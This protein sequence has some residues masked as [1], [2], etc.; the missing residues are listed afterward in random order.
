MKADGTAPGIR[1]AKSNL[2]GYRIVPDSPVV[3]TTISNL[4]KNALALA[5]NERIKPGETYNIATYAIDR[6]YMSSTKINGTVEFPV[7]RQIK[8][9][10]S[11]IDY[12]LW[13]IRPNG[14]KF[15]MTGSII[16]RSQD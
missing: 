14:Q 10:G 8:S 3:A 13:R 15:K 7:A 4:N 16:D 5:N 6:H 11:I 1:Q 2:L 12:R 9:D